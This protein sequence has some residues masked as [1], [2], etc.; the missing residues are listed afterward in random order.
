MSMRVLQ[1]SWDESNKKGMKGGGGGGVERTKC[2]PAHINTDSDWC[3][4]LS[5]YEIE[6]NTSIKPAKVALEKPI[7]QLFKIK[8]FFDYCKFY[9]GM[10]C[11]ELF[12]MGRI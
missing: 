2:L 1:E 11:T 4:A 6:I 7:C 10:C 3:G 12:H 9:S 5:V 8:R